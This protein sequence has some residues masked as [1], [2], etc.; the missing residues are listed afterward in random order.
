MDAVNLFLDLFEWILFLV[1]LATGFFVGRFLER[2]HYA[3]IREREKLYAPV[4]A[5]GARF[6]PD[7]KTPQDARLVC[8]CVVISSDYFKKFVL[9]LR[10]FIGGRSRGY[11]T[12]LDRGRREATLRMKMEARRMGAKLVV[13]AFATLGGQVFV[14]RGLV[15]KMPDE[16][17]LALVLAHEAAHVK[18]R[19]PVRSAG[20]G[21]A[22]ALVLS[23]VGMSGGSAG[24]VASMA[25]GV[26][27]LSFSRS[28]ESDADREAL[29]AVRRLYGH[30][31]GPTELFA[32]LGSEGRPEAGRVAML[33]THP[34]SAD[35]IE[36]LA[37]FAASK[38]WPADGPRA[39]MPAAL[40]KIMAPSRAKETKP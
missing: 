11:E 13:N 9:G 27:L 22:V 30:A 5:F 31:G 23:A 33:Q 29:A 16:N 40:S 39:P 12:L 37:A 3:S 1:L 24:D 21:I 20:R 4:L 25:G 10:N 28:Q 26:T 35:R 7:M 34:L 18:L 32:L 15:A 2:Q 17:T 8:G 14:H 6:P 36:E 19:H 38:G